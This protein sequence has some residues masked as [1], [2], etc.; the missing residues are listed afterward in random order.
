MFPC[1]PKLLDSV[2]E[3]PKKICYVPPKQLTMLFKKSDVPSF[4]KILNN[5]LLFT[6]TPGGLSGRGELYPNPRPTFDR[7]QE[8]NLDVCPI[9]FIFPDF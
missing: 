6:K 4:P 9:T 7:V 2:S 5:V 1:S 3:F 8:V